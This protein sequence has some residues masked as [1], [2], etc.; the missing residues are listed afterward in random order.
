[1]T[2]PPG[3][4]YPGP[5]IP[6]GSPG[7]GTPPG[8]PGPGQPGGPYPPGP[9]Y[10]PPGNP[11]P[12]YPPPGSYQPEPTFP[13]P[14]PPPPGA[15]VPPV[16][17][18]PK[19]RR[20]GLIVIGIAAAVGLLLVVGIGAV[21][22]FLDWDKM[23]GDNSPKKSDDVSSGQPIYRKLPKCDQMPTS[24]V[25]KL[26][27]KMELTT[28]QYSEP[29]EPSDDLSLSCGWDN[30]SA[31][32]KKPEEDRM[33]DVEIWGFGDFIT[34]GLASAD[35]R[36]RES[37]DT[38]NK[39]ANKAD[40]NHHYGPVQQVPEVAAGAFAQHDLITSSWTYA[41]TDVFL[42]VDN[43]VVDVSFKGSDGPDGREKPIGESTSRQGAM[44]ITKAVLKNLAA[45]ADCKS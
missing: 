16:A 8:Y 24:D 45:C 14:Q 4:S 35:R 44:T 25:A 27:P 6:P 40:G 22:V 31:D 5:G 11:G 21:V 30:I 37:L 15:P 13:P 12:G 17:P 7:P 26:V 33:V 38:A 2:Q 39:Y 18:P 9:G 19:P 41:G 23:F 1:M 28:N 34:T 29:Q 42:K 43:L 10:P 36:Y 20:T 3:P 32:G